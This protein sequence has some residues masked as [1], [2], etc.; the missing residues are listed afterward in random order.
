MQTPLSIMAQFNLKK[1]CEVEMNGNYEIELIN[2]LR[3]PQLAHD[4]RIF[5]TSQLFC[6]LPES[7]RNIIEDLYDHD[8]VLVGIELVNKS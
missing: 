4:H 2:L 1:I 8:R 7:L 6:K 3:N 5:P